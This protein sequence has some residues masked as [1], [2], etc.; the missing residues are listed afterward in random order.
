MMKRFNMLKSDYSDLGLE[1]C[2]PKYNPAR[3]VISK[4]GENEVTDLR[5]KIEEF[6]DQEIRNKK[7]VN[8]Q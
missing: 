7:L 3:I 6:E 2:N 4:V 8:R 1:I 5:T